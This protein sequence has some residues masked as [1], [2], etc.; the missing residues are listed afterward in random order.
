MTEDT[1]PSPDRL[2]IWVK[3]WERFQP[4]SDRPGLPWLRI[5]TTL[6]DD[7]DWLTLSSDDRVVLLTIW[8]QTQ[9]LG[10]GLVEGDLK[11]LCALSNVGWSPRSRNL[12]RLVQAGFIELSTTKGT[13][14]DHQ[15]GGLEERRDPTGLKK[16]KEENAR[17]ATATNGGASRSEDDPPHLG[18]TELAAHLERIANERDKLADQ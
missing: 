10:S 14:A 9:K 13:P 3:N 5:Y 17:A 2:W 6:L 8:C 15:N 18:D 7:G 12:E 1:S 16:R 4:R 11:R